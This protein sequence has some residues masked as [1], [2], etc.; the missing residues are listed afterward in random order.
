MKKARFGSGG[1]IKVFVQKIEPSNV[2]T[3]DGGCAKICHVGDD[4]DS[5][6]FVRLQSWDE[7]HKHAE[8][9]ELP[10]R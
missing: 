7:T 1:T 3:E 9:S 5:G 2:D 6:I 10:G 4:R 8:I